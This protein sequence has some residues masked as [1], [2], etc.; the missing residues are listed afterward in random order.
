MLTTTFQFTAG[1]MNLSFRFDNGM[2]QEVHHSHGNQVW[3]DDTNNPELFAFQIDGKRQSAQ[4]IVFTSFTDITE[5]TGIRHVT[6]SGNNKQVAVDCHIHL[7]DSISVVKVFPLIRSV[8][9]SP[10]KI[11]RV[12]SISLQLTPGYD[13]CLSFTGNWGSEFEPISPD[14]SHDVILESRTGRSSKGNHP[15]VSLKR[16]DNSVFCCA[17]AWSGNWVLRL[18]HNKPG[19]QQFSGGLNDW[20]FSKILRTNESLEAPSIVLATGIDLNDASQNLARVGRKY[21]YPQ[22]AFLDRIPVEWNHW[23]PYEDAEINEQVFL[24][25]IVKAEEMGFDVC[26]LDAG[27]FGPADAGTFW[28]HYRGDWNIINTERFPNGIRPL[29]D[30]VHGHGMK[31]GIWCEIEA[32][33]EKAQ[34]AIDHPE[35]V[36]RRDEKPLGYVCFGNPQVQEWAFQTISHLVNDYKADWIKLDFNVDPGSGCNRTDHGHQEGDGLFAHYTGYY[37]FLRRI[38]DCFPHVILESCSSGGLRIDLG[39]LSHLD[40]TFLSDPDWPDHDLQIFWGASCM[41]APN[42]LLHWTFS[43]WRNLNPP[44]YQ[45]FDPFD[46]SLT[47]KKWDYLSHISMLGMYGLSQK[48]PKLPAWM[49]QRVVENNAIYKDIVQKFVRQGD[50]YRLTEQ[51]RRSGEGERWAAFQYSLPDE[52]QNLLFVFR[53]PGAE[54]ERTIHL[55]NLSANQQYT[56]QGIGTNEDRTFTGRCLME[57]GLPFSNLDEEESVILMINRSS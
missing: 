49:A 2:L 18:E 55:H 31:F 7:F 22:N 36:A 56:V 12:D 48:L 29:A 27:W 54:K 28:E 5:E 19:V 42:A 8:N 10:I 47:K 57:D 23:W 21:W 39:L 51:P 44:P 25:N 53:M 14:L 16:P 41:L 34:I 11:D 3:I 26:T 9:S 4:D 52:D 24:D 40:C 35:F 33:G 50:L 32:L 37:Q 17:V 45:N 46:P 15:W 20:E 13:N 43:H 38:R 30:A 6:L 1:K